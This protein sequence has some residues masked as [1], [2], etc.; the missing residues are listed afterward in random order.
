M[1]KVC[2]LSV[3]FCEV[4]MLSCEPELLDVAVPLC[5]VMPCGFATARH[6]L[7]SATASE[8]QQHRRNLRAEK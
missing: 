4:V 5:T 8:S 7:P 1:L 2:Q 3:A 6:T